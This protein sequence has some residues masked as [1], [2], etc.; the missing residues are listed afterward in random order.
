MDELAIVLS[1]FLPSDDKAPQHFNALEP[2][3]CTCAL[4]ELSLAKLS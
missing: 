4:E 2:T 3:L 1:P